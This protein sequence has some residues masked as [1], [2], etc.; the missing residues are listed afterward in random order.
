MKGKAAVFVG[1]RLP[2][3]I[4]EYP[5]PEVEPQGILVKVSLA[6]ICGSDLHFWRG[7]IPWLVFPS[8]LGHEMTGRVHQL[9]S[10]VSTDSTGQPLAV[11]DRVIC[12]YTRPC[13]TCLACKSWRPM[14]CINLI[15]FAG[16][17]S[18]DQPP[19][20]IGAFAEYYYITPGQFV[21]KVPDEL[22]DE[23]AAP[24]NCALTT[25]M[26][27]LQ[28]GGVTLGDTVVIQGA[29][30][31]GINAI[32]VAKEMG[33]GQVIVIDKIEERLKLARAFG[34]DHTISL[35]DYPEPRDRVRRVRELTAGR[36]AE[37]VLEVVGV[38]QVIAEG[39]SMLARSVIQPS[40]YVIVGNLN[41]CQTFQFDPSRL[42]TR[43]GKIVTVQGVAPWILPLALDFLKRTK[44]KYP[45]HQILH[46]FKL[47]EINEALEQASEGKVTRAA[48]VP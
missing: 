42:L 35:N 7:E 22:S 9:G 23:L 41:P 20:F 14:D 47:E 2:M 5:L 10:E 30:G 25:V 24:V 26:L 48:I 8:I 18:C 40:T 38:P 44:D 11:G 39:I 43:A 31:L 29:G 19:H 34:A 3:E 12:T 16:A 46:K 4:R 6:N 36:G 21:V 17:S 1:A 13:G 32:A 15:T 27:A 28:S 45:F 37:V 33:A